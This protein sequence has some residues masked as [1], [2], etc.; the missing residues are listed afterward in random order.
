[1]ATL[2]FRIP[3]DNGRKSLSL[4]K[5]AQAEQGGRGPSVKGARISYSTYKFIGEVQGLF[6]NS[7]SPSQADQLCCDSFPGTPKSF[8]ALQVDFIFLNLSF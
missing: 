7:F 1:M 3:E 2:G 6:G 4:S 5:G 8:A